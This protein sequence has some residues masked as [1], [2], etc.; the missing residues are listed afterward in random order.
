MKET[1]KIKKWQLLRYRS[2]K[3]EAD[4]SAGDFLTVGKR[5]MHRGVMQS[6]LLPPAC[7]AIKTEAFR[8]CRRLKT[9]VLPSANNI[10]LSAGVFRGCARL[11]EVSNSEQLSAIGTAAF[12]NCVMLENLTFGRSLHRIGERAFYGCRSLT[13]LRLPGSVESIGRAAFADCTE[14]AA[15]DCSELTVASEELFRG[16]ISLAEIAIPQTW[17]RLPDGIFR[18]CAALSEVRIPGQV[19]SIGKHAF[20]GCSSLASVTLEL[21][22]TRIGAH[23]FA[24]TPCLREVTV[25]HSVKRLGFG[26]FGLGKRAEEEKI[27]LTVENDYMARRL[28]RMVRRC[29]SA[30]CVKV[31]LVGKSIEERKRERRRASLTTDPVH[32]VDFEE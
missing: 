9:I 19:Q 3:N 26:A 7:S 2:Q 6:I 14:I 18:D 4:L 5:A 30:G 12:E 32:L 27:N 15:V 20:A 8:D 28:R 25:P 1:I 31:S 10:G 23:A 16:C 24:D 22:V 11:H 17:D 21:G 29:G 13:E